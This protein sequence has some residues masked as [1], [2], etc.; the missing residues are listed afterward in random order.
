MA[1]DEYDKGAHF[2]RLMQAF[3]RTEPQYA[4]LY[5]EVWRWSEYPERGTRT[6]TGVDLVARNRD[7]GELTA[8]QCKFF[9]PTTTVTK[10]MLDSFLS[11]SGKM[12]EDGAPEFSSRLV[13]S[14]SDKWGKNAEDAIS[15]QSIP[16]ERLRVQDLDDSS[17]DW[18]QFVW[19]EP[20][21]L[22]KKRLKTPFDYQRTA[23]D[24]VV[25]GFA[26]RDRGKLIMACGTGKTFTSLRLAERV[27]P[28]GG[29]VLFLMPSIALLSQTLKEW[30]IQA[31]VP[32]RSFAVCSDV[33]VGKRRTEEDI[34]VTDLA[35]P[36][37]T[38]ASALVKQ[39]ESGDGSDKLTVI[40]STYQSLPV[41]SKAQGM[42]LP[43]FDLIVSDEA[44][45]TTGAAINSEDESAF[46]KVH[47]Q[48]FVQ[49]KKR[50]YM[51]ATPRIFSDG[52][53]KKAGEIGAK[54]ADMDDEAVYGPE[55][56]RLGFGQAVSMGRLTDYKVLVLAVDESFVA[57]EFQSLMSQDGYELAM[58]DTAKIVGTWNGLSKRSVIP[59]EYQD[60]PSPM[61]RAVMFA[62][63]IATSRKLADAFQQVVEGEIERID[64][65]GEDT[66]RLLHAEAR[67]VDG[68]QSMLVRNEKLDWLKEPSPDSTVRILSNAKCLS[69]GVDVPALD[70]VMFMNPRKSVVDVVQSVG[71]VMRKMA[72][73]KFGYVILPIA[74]P[75]GVEPDE[76]LNN[77]D[78]YRVVWQ[79]LQALRAHDERFDAEVNKIDLTK[80]TNR[81]MVDVIGAGG[82][83][84]EDEEDA[85]TKGA[86][87][88]QGALQLD[89]SKI[90]AW[91]EAILSKIVQKVG[92]RRYW[93]N[94]AKDVG[95]IAK[96][97]AARINALVNGDNKRIRDEFEAFTEGLRLNLNPDISH[98][99]AVQMLSQHLITQPVFD[100]LFEGYAFSENNPVSQ[101]MNAMVQVLDGENLENE[102][103]KL[104]SFYESVR[105]RAA[106]ID[107][108]AAKQTI[109]KELYEKFF[110]TAFSKTS[111][112]LGIVYTPNEIVDFILHSVNDILKD[113]FDTSISDEGVHVLDPF[114]G[115]GTFIVRLLQSGL[116]KP[117]DLARKYRYE[118]HANEI[119]LLAYYVAAI[120]I[121]E[122]YHS[123]R[124][125]KYVPFDGIVLTDT[126]QMF[127]DDDELDDMG[128]FQANNDRVIAQKERDIRVII[129]NPPYSA[130]QKS[131]NDDN[132]NNSYPTLDAKIR[133][134]YARQ[135]TA[136]LK[137]NLYDSYIRAI[138]WASD[139][140][141]DEGI[142]AYVSNGGY[143]DSNTAD[144]LRLSLVDG[145]TSVYIFNLRGNQRTAGEQSRREG[146]KVFG[147]GSRAT[148]A[149][150]V[151]VKNPSRQS[152]ASVYYYDIGDYLTREQKLSAITQ[153]KSTAGVPWRAITPS[154]EGDWI[155]QR[156]SSFGSFVPIGEKDTGG[157]SRGIRVFR[158]HS[159]GLK[160]NRD[161]WVYGYS[162]ESMLGNAE[163]LSDVYNAERER[164][165]DAGSPKDAAS[166]VT[167]DERQI[168][169]TSGLLADMARGKAA[170]FDESKVRRAMYRPYSLQQA[171][172]DAQMNERQGRLNDMF[173]SASSP[174][175]GI[176]VPAPGSSAPPF[177]TLMTNVMPDLGLAGI[178]AV[179]FF[180]RYTYRA[181]ENDPASLFPEDGTLGVFDEMDGKLTAP[182]APGFERIDNITDEILTDY[183]QSFGKSVTKDDIFFYVY[184]LLHSREYRAEFEADL[185]KMLPRIPKVGAFKEFVKAGRALAELH[186]NYETV[187]PYPLIE[188]GT[189]NASLRVTKMRYAKEGRQENK[190]TIIYNDGITL[191]GIPE[192]AQE[193]L[194]GSRSALDW[195]IERYQVKT[196]KASGIV[197]DPNA[198]G[199]ER[200]DPRYILD[201]IKRITTVSVETV[202]IVNGLPS[203]EV[204]GA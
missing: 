122:T 130:G 115:T 96:A 153:F 147:A 127:E 101:V 87:K 191:T 197:N 19:N 145:F 76:A 113:E 109:V 37:T 69:E 1:F 181:V 152:P 183:R 128:I 159:G 20:A 36:A 89:F 61:Q 106:G 107:D 38:N 150:A 97:H 180:P 112:K 190:T 56:H 123:L 59:G 2:E 158:T 119:V 120:N 192:E 132:A 163:R 162:I 18:S 54:L 104:E 52:T 148:I 7:T 194:L 50:L 15:G 108:A 103:A 6:D 203:L 164:W 99:D 29:T 155:N 16:V 71:R 5:D 23:I 193:Y 11:A 42:G 156:S 178:S 90:E 32:M 199:D 144:G 185:K 34:P 78:K 134:T 129:G 68:T 12:T 170:I 77:N 137:N 80:K 179:Q 182:A 200:G 48:S 114:T 79:V 3:L 25:A 65:S 91:R 110:S 125:G 63:D 27:V 98:D 201:L 58:E 49:G 166:F 73:K 92:Q 33:S 187:E 121:E 184:G 186:L 41:I 55:F 146:G 198:W 143:I 14:T 86:D 21:K 46:M 82:G 62:K 139:R 138:R 157:A 124:G 39:F 26:D 100:A 105:T 24:D 75:G 154:N 28:L 22:E 136:S 174:N 72:G 160:T 195:I 167:K 149:I 168:K 53:R 202:K 84:G 176:S 8:I 133:D 13:I 116:I 140:I 40:F 117:H 81:L 175:V 70:A 35:F 10:A 74:I 85:A 64:G 171:Y 135:S 60:D 118:L 9:A 189:P 30:T 67:H 17:I 196:D 172:F 4:E 126:F 83:K 141:G 173:P 188:N 204:I 131:G 169:W 51:T 45:R 31:E 177:M 161:A 93:E 88:V 66:S 165:V 95:E 44:H 43:E 102:T 142:V 94:W 57:R 151:L 47:D 111:E